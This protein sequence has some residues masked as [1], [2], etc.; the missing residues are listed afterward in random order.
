[1]KIA[2]KINK[3]SFIATLILYLTLFL[4]LYAQIVLGVIQILIALYISFNMQLLTKKMKYQIINYW[5]YVTLYSILATAFF[6]DWI[7]FNDNN[8]LLIITIII[9]P[10]SIAT[11]FT[12][13]L[14]KIAKQ[15]ETK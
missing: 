12:I 4:G 8:L 11:Y 2:Q 7:D 3:F 1:M 5:I 6:N 10:M 14:N 15:N 9:I 13:T